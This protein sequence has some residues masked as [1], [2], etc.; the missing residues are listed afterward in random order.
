MH[1]HPESLIINLTDYNGRV[2]T[3]DGKTSEVHAKAGSVSWRQALTHAVE[4][5]DSPPM[6][7]LIVE[8]KNP[9]SRPA[10]GN[11]LATRACPNTVEASGGLARSARR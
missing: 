3:P 8:P 1:S 5:I 6:E 10:G 7:G 11:E 2:T 4:N 9:A